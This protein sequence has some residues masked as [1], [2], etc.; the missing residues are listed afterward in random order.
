MDK[1]PKTGGG[2]VQ[3]NR[4]SAQTI[5]TE[6]I[7]LKAQQKYLDANQITLNPLNSNNKEEMGQINDVENLKTELDLNLAAYVGAMRMDVGHAL[8]QLKEF[9]KT[10][11]SAE[12]MQQCQIKEYRAKILLVDRLLREMSDGNVAEVERLRQQFMAMEEE[13]ARFSDDANLLRQHE[14]LFS[15]R[16][17]ALTVRQ[18]ISAPIERT[19]CDEVRQFDRFVA[20]T[21]GHSGGW[22][23]EEHQLF[24]KVRG[25]FLSNIDRIWQE[26][27][28]ILTGV[29][30]CL[31]EQM[32]KVLY[33]VRQLSVSF[34]W[35]FRGRW[36]PAAVHRGL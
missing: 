26:L 21:G 4:N 14:R 13:L 22:S 35:Y 15:G 36:R 25:K 23:D 19:D 9:Q 11:M 28:P 10:M 3:P 32:F 1:R 16:W 2:S 31:C 34:G 12:S 7:K 17:R 20:E 30:V 24:V 27:Q 8:C 18:A 29:C 6:L 5:L 33:R